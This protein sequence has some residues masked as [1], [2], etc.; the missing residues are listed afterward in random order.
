MTTKPKAKHA[1]MDH[2]HKSGS[3]AVPAPTEENGKKA[4][5]R[6]DEAAATDAPVRIEILG[7]RNPRDTKDDKK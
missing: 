7:D 1:Q 6:R 4:N 3:H 2:E 5:G